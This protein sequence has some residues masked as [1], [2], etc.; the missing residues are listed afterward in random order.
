MMKTLPLMFTLRSWMRE[1]HPNPYLCNIVLVVLVRQGGKKR[2]KGILTEKEEIKQPL[3][4]H[5]TAMYAEN[6]KGYI[7]YNN[8]S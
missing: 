8:Y 6:Q 5:K 7:D 1:D 3:F 2:N 4:K